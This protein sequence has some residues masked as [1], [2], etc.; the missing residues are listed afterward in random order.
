MSF[1]K[2]IG[3]FFAHLFSGTKKTWKKISP[4]V[5][6]ALMYGSDVIDTINNY[7]DQ[8]PDF[9][10][11]IIAKKYPELDRAHLQAA[12]A[13]ASKDLKIAEGV[14]NDDLETII[15]NLQ[16]YMAGLKGQA[17]AKISNFL[18]QG[19]AIFTAPAGTKFGMITSLIEFVYQTFFKKK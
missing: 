11:D 6:K 14:N 15:K 10:I 8:T 2:V 17:W 16:S 19:I 9:I 18:A 4:E 7:L 1:F 5:Q 12:L 3:D 13:E